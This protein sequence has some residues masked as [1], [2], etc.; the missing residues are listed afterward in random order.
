MNTALFARSALVLATL[1]GAAA[2]Q[3]QYTLQ[4]GGMYLDPGATA[5]ATTGALT[6][7]DALSLNVQPVST[8]FFGVSRSI[9]ANWDLQLALGTPPTHDIKLRIVNPA[10]LP[11]SVSAHA[12]ETIGSVRQ[13]AP[14]LFANYKFN[15]PEDAFRPFIGLGLNYTMFD[16]AS[17]NALNNQINGGVTNAKLSDSWG[18]AAQI[19]ASYKLSG[20]WSLNASISTADVSTTLTTNTLGLERKTKVR[21]QPA[22]YIISLGYSF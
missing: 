1:F 3:A 4:F 9:D 10:L 20:P 15:Q 18:L 13:I 6:P 21:F 8:I 14:T 11:P 19:G 5:N 2:S 7:P 12:G 16:Q 17:S 22:A